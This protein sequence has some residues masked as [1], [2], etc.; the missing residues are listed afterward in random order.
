MADQYN[1][2]VQ[3]YVARPSMFFSRISSQLITSKLFW[4]TE[5]PRVR[6]IESGVGRE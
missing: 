2:A 4:Q 6:G 5:Q 3:Q 1:Y